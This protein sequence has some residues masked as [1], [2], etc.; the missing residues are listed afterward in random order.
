MAL[1]EYLIDPEHSRIQFRVRH[2]GLSEVTG[3]FAGFSGRIL[4]AKDELAKSRVDTVIDV[5]SITTELE[6]RDKHLRSPDF[7]DAGKF[8]KI[9]YLSS[10]IVG[11]DPNQ[12]SIK[13]VLTMKGVSLPVEIQAT[14]IGEET[15]PWG[16]KRIAFSGRTGLNRKDFGLTWSKVLETGSLVVGDQVNITLDIQAVKKQLNL[17]GIPQ[18]KDSVQK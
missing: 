5:K 18:V 13:G 17:P 4:Y 9:S 3:N 10:E 16:Y 7:F 15:D 8:A 2:L 6:K 14:F 1:D 11:T 12:F